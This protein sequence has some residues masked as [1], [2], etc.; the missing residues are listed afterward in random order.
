MEANE[1]TDQRGMKIEHSET[2]EQRI[3]RLEREMEE[4]DER[5]HIG[6]LVPPVIYSER[7]VSESRGS[8]D[9]SGS[10]LGLSPDLTKKER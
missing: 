2:N 1:V 4:R 9:E 3:E 5:N 8:Q 7:S 10:Q 6:G